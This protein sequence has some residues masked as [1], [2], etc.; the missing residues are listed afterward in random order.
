MFLCMETY[1]I[2]ISVNYL[3]DDKF[4]FVNVSVALSVDCAI[5]IELRFFSAQ[6]AHHSFEDDEVSFFMDPP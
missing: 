6:E 3:L 1:R 4:P 2:I 5:F